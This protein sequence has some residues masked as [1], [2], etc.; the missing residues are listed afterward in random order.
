M[1]GT[2]RAEGATVAYG[3]DRPSGLNTGFYL[4]P[5]VLVG[6]DDQM[7]VVQTEV[8]GPVVCV[9]G[10]TDVDDVVA[11]ANALP[12]GLTANIW[13]ADVNAALRTAQAVDAGYVYVNGSG[14]R[15]STLPFG[16]WKQS[17][18]G[19]ENG[20]EELLSYTREKSITITLH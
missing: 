10:W 19:Q 17:G 16:G 2:A 8:F 5:T 12:L 14:R 4:T 20:P 9:L 6:L 18:I 11:R 15:N 7:T 1:V 3:G 13:T